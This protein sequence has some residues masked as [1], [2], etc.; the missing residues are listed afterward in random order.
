[1]LDASHAIDRQNANILDWRHV[2]YDLLKKRKRDVK[3][4]RERAEGGGGG[5]GGAGKRERREA[6]RS[7]IW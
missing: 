6:D 7:T 4:M 3:G 1:M 2:D 5:G